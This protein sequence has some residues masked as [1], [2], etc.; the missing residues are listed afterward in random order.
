MAFLFIHSVLFSF[1]VFAQ[2][3]G[4]VGSCVKLLRQRCSWRRV[5]GVTLLLSVSSSPLAIMI[6]MIMHYVQCH[7][8]C[9]PPAEVEHP[10]GQPLIWFIIRI[11]QWTTKVRVSFSSILFTSQCSCLSLSF[12]LL[13]LLSLRDGQF[14]GQLSTFLWGSTDQGSPLRP[15]EG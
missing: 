4:G 12:F 6:M 8:R 10:K 14:Q 7:M 3:A 15:G 5:T 1:F 9:A 13:L 11:L 2:T